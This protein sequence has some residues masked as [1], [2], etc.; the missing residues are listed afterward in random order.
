MNTKII[1]AFAQDPNPKNMDKLI[2]LFENDATEEDIL[3][4][5]LSIAKNARENPGFPAV[6]IPSTG[7]PGSLST[8]LCPLF[9]S[10]KGN[11]VLKLGVPG[12]P[13]G[14]IDILAQIPNY[15]IIFTKDEYVNLLSNTN[16]IHFLTSEQFLPLDNILYNYR[17]NKKKVNVP[18]LAIAS[19]LSKKIALGLSF[20]GLDVRVSEFNNF[21][22]DI[23]ECRNYAN[24]F[25]RIADKLDI[26]SICFINDTS[27]QLQ[28]YIGRGEALLALQK[29]LNDE[30]DLWL[31]KHI[32]ECENMVD[33]FIKAFRLKNENGDYKN[34]LLDNL[35]WQGANSKDFIEYVAKIGQKK[36]T[37]IRA[38]REGYLQFNLNCIREI[39]ISIQ[40]KNSNEPFADNIGIVLL[41][42][43]GSH[44]KK[45][46]EILSLRCDEEYLE[47][48][49]AK[50]IGTYSINNF[51]NNSRQK[52][53]V[54][55]NG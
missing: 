45:N 55:Y 6:D 23:H 8:L 32:K 18:N 39:L 49:L 4:L 29:L 30:Q 11:K 48:V 20:V 47:I 10:A 1:N 26:N 2:S 41:K 42:E 44:V 21:G 19:I 27:Q 38:D 14:G 53:E 33:I 52:M 51:D 54:I 22:K 9:L 7:G 24:K 3:H 40:A 35:K 43:S 34:A 50:I 5:T 28:P 36:R 17:E 15:K 46:D 13:A 25:N 37:I 12:R 16:Y 31:Q